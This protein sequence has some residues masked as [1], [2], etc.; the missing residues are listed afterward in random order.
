MTDL[1]E[2]FNAAIEPLPPIDDENF[3]P[4]FD[5]FAGRQVF[6]LGDGTHGTSEFYRARAE[7]TKR[8][9]KVHGYTIVAVEADWPDAEAID[10]HVRMRPGPKGASMKA[11]IDY[12][13]R[14]HP[15]AGKE[16]R[17]LYG[18]LDPWADDPVAYG[19]ASMQGMRDC[20]AQV[21]QI[22]RDFLN[23]RLEYM[24]SD[25]LDGEEFQSGK[26]NAFLVRDAEQ[27]YKAMYWS[28]TSS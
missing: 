17:E 5:S 3:A 7:I 2:L 10:R 27:Y 21:I 11:V 6:L 19:L 18:C 9:I 24:K 28:S 13:D 12:L 22:L 26:Q 16:A 14:V 4:H 8:L 25:S 1:Q 15:A 20:E 23:N